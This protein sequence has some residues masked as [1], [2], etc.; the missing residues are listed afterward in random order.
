MKLFLDTANIEDIKTAFDM[1]AIS[2]VTTNPSLISKEPKGSFFEHIRNIANICRENGHVPLSAEVFSLNRQGIVSEAREIIEKVG[3]NNLNIKV[4]IGVEQL[5]AIK[6]LSRNSI[7]VNC[8]C[9]FTATQMQLA[10]AA[11]ASYVSLFYNRLIDVGGSPL[12]VLERVRTFIDDEHLD[13]Q[14][15]AGSIRNAYDLED[16]WDAGAHIVTAG[17]PVVKKS[18]V[19]PKTTESIEGFMEDFKEWM[20]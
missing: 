8:T 15:I 9:C 12:K 18:L 3:Y 13:C 17:L 2:G 20:K 14:I 5:A 11:G 1:G 19:H 6:D 16:A 10:A 7:E 4:P